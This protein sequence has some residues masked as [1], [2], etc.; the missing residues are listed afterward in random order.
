MLTDAIKSLGLSRAYVAT[1]LGIGAPYLSMLEHGKKT[2]SLELA[3]KIERLIGIPVASW[4]E[5]PPG[6]DIEFIQ[7][8]RE[9]ATP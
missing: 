8:K 3:V 4:V 6:W 1:R 9:A 2:P 7:E 5:L